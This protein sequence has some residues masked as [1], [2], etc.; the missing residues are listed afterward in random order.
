M[1]ETHERCWWW[2][3]RGRGGRGLMKPQQKQWKVAKL[4]YSDI[5]NSTLCIL[6]KCLEPCLDLYI[7]NISNAI[8]VLKPHYVTSPQLH[9][10]VQIFRNLLV[11]F[12]TNVNILGFS[13]KMYLDFDDHV[14]EVTI[15]SFQH[16]P[17]YQVFP[18]SR[19][20]WGCWKLW[21]CTYIHTV[22]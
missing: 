16:F 5:T 20:L 18:S 8:V 14:A 13:S 7:K 21:G 6:A 9:S 11:T 17:K 12:K 3:R 2:K 1:H 22:V 15:F 10:M 19:A 4:T